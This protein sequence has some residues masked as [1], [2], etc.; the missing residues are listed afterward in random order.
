MKVDESAKLE[1]FKKLIP[2]YTDE[3]LEAYKELE[4]LREKWKKR[5]ERTST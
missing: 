3:E 2:K 1:L 4:K 5:N